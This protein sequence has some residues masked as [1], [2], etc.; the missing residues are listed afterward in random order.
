MPYRL[1]IF[2]SQKYINIIIADICVTNFVF[3]FKSFMSSI[4]PTHNINVI[5][6]KH[7]MGISMLNIVLHANRAAANPMYTPTPPKTGIGIRLS[8]RAF[9]LS[10]ISFCNAYFTN[11]GCSN[12]TVINDM[13]N[14]V[15]G[16]VISVIILWFVSY[17]SYQKLCQLLRKY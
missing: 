4:S 9:G 13:S 8:R 6:M 17:I 1:S 3:G 14:A 15:M 10:T 7:D 16:S 2:R 5:A 11:N 12:M